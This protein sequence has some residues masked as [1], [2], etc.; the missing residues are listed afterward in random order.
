MRQTKETSGLVLVVEDN[1]NIS[2][3]IGE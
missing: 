1:R 3:M 2:E